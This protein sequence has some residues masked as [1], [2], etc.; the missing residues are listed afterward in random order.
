MNEKMTSKKRRLVTDTEKKKE[1]KSNGS[2][3]TMEEVKRRSDESSQTPTSKSICPEREI[4]RCEGRT[5]AAE[6]NQKKLQILKIRNQLPASA[7]GPN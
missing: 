5:W 7:G 4:G 2:T 1:E 3:N 6:K